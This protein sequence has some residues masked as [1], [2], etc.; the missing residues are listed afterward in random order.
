MFKDNTYTVT[1]SS[2]FVAPV[3]YTNLSLEEAQ[4]LAWQLKSEQY[5]VSVEIEDPLHELGICHP[6]D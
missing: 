4:E 3:V 5:K 1:G 2:A 6:C